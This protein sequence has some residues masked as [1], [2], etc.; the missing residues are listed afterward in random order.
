MRREALSGL[1]PTLQQEGFR[2][3]DD[4]VRGSKPWTS[5]REQLGAQGDAVLDQVCQQAD[6]SA[7]ADNTSRVLRAAATLAYAV[8]RDYKYSRRGRAA[9]KA[10]GAQGEY[11]GMWELAILG[12]Q[13]G[14]GA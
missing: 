5:F 11:V 2:R 10:M 14:S 9:M 8:S 6:T 12:Y 3:L 13:E 1:D 4:Q 7:K